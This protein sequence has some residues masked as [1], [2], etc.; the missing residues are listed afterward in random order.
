MASVSGLEP[1][2]GYSVS[3]NESSVNNFR[4][5]YKSGWFPTEE[6]R[7]AHRGARGV[8]Q[9]YMHL[10]SP[11]SGEFWMKSLVNFKTMKIMNHDDSKPRNVIFMFLIMPSI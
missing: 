7:R 5:R 1:S 8:T 6:C 10:N 4:Y 9:T 2:K 11:N 3:I